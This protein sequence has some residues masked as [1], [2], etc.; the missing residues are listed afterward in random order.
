MATSAD[1]HSKLG[2]KRQNHQFDISLSFEQF[3]D[4]WEYIWHELIHR[5]SQPPVQWDQTGW[6]CRPVHPLQMEKT[7]KERLSI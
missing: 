4:L 3:H 5:A 7:Q 1:F 6:D 2:D